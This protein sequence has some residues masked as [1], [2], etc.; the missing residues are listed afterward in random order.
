MSSTYTVTRDQI[1]SLALRKLGVLE[2]GD[3]P[4]A[5]TVANAALSLNLFIK[6]LSVEGLKLWKNTEIIIPLTTNQTTYVLGGT[7]STLMYDSLAPT[8][9][10]TD[11][12]LKVIQG[13]YRSTET[14]IYIDTPVM[15]IS[16]HRVQHIRI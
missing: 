13:F 6:Q 14:T 10:I 16:K 7:T 4:D 12:P 3:T 9:A 1:I 8:V 5:N 15:I 2:I 11:K